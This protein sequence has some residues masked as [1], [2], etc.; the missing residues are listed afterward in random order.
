MADPKPEAT[1]ENI[2]LDFK[3]LFRG[4]EVSDDMPKLLRVI[5]KQANV[6]LQ[7]DQLLAMAFDAACIREDYFD[8]IFEKYLSKEQ[9]ENVCLKVAK[10]AGTCGDS[11]VF[12]HFYSKL[13]NKAAIDDYQFAR[14][15]TCAGEKGLY[16]GWKYFAGRIKSKANKT[17]AKDNEDM[18]KFAYCA[19]G[20]EYRWEDCIAFLKEIRNVKLRQVTAADL[21]LSAA[22]K[23][24]NIHKE[25]TLEILNLANKNYRED[26][27]FIVADIIGNHGHGGYCFK[28]FYDMIKDPKKKA[29]IGARLMTYARKGEDVATS[30]MFLDLAGHGD[31]KYAW[32][33]Q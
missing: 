30:E 2:L 14:Y 12:Q 8:Q 9:L 10:E 4:A 17:K 15:A 7:E 1:L 33:G 20:K 16:A 23:E 18:R 5:S 13:T 27:A 19:A 3:Q 11:N 22:R 32:F 31:L 21:V 25:K 28:K 6:P 29:V 26:L 24:N